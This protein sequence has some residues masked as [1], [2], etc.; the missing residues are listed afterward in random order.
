[1]QEEFFDILDE[2]GNKTGKIKSR[3]AVHKDGDWHRAV[4]IWIIN[5]KREILLQR[6]CPTK[7]SDPNMLD[8]SCAGH[9][10]TGD[11]PIIGALR[12]LE[13]ELSLVVKENDL[14]YI[15]TLKR[16][17]KHN[18]GFK[19]NEYDDMFLLHI[20]KDI[21]DL[22]FQKEEISEI[23]F[24]PYPKFKEMVYNRQEDLVIYPDEYQ[25]LFELL[26]KEFNV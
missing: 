6:R 21:D 18:D 17:P 24:I 10:T 22:S 1:M 20:D 14:K 13:E 8:M 11:T 5:S 3:T 25:I 19:D 7:D 4:H 12:E 2:Q 23:F 16:S 26:D 15:T 9:L